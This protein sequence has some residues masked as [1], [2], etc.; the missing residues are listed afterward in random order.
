MCIKKILAA[1]LDTMGPGEL[2]TVGREWI[3]WLLEAHPC[4][5]SGADAEGILPAPASAMGYTVSELCAI[6]GGSHSRM[7]S[8]LAAGVFGNPA[9]LKPAPPHWNV[10]PERARA[11]LEKLGQGYTITPEGLQAPV[12]SGPCRFT[13]SGGESA[14]SSSAPVGEPP[15]RP[16]PKKSRVRPPGGRHNGWRSVIG[17]GPAPG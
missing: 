5:C 16:G 17:G 9:T 3:Q 7:K 2:M 11:L 10:P 1:K 13:A 14:M 4:A 12:E 15:A 8:W 6:F